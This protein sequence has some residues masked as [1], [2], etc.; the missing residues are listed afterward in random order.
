[1]NGN[2]NNPKDLV[3]QVYSYYGWRNMRMFHRK[4][5]DEAKQYCETLYKKGKWLKTRVA[6]QTDSMDRLAEYERIYPYQ[7]DK[8]G[9][10]IIPDLGQ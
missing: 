4:N 10:Y 2:S 3:V 8:T 7:K 1:M 5:F 6:I 9:N